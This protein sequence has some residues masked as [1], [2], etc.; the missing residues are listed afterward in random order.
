MQ[1]ADYTRNYNIE[2]LN[3]ADAVCTC[4]CIMHMHF[5]VSLHVYSAICEA[6][7]ATNAAAWAFWLC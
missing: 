4:T 6:A 2:Y 5:H 1:F 3:Y 7:G